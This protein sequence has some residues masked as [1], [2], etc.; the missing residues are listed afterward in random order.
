MYDKTYYSDN[1]F[2]SYVK[3]NNSGFKNDYTKFKQDLTKLLSNYS[4]VPL[5]LSFITWSI[6]ENILFIDLTNNS[7]SFYDKI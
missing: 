1:P 5:Q 4:R 2:L 7:I 6:I 3:S